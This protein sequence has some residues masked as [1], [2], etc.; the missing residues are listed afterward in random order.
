MDIAKKLRT[1]VVTLLLVSLRDNPG[2]IEV[3]YV[4]IDGWLIAISFVVVV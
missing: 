1:F 4:E 3:S 2:F